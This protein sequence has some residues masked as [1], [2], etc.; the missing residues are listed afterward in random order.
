M[1]VGWLPWT[2]EIKTKGV[3]RPTTKDVYLPILE[4]LKLEGIEATVTNCCSKTRTI[5]FQWGWKGVVLHVPR[6]NASQL[7]AHDLSVGLGARSRV[8][9]YKLYVG[10][11]CCPCGSRS[12]CTSCMCKHDMGMMLHGVIFHIFYHMSCVCQPGAILYGC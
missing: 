8:H 5:L 10:I 1:C 11:C 12:T 6:P 3:V 7:Q 2:G 9:C 4:R